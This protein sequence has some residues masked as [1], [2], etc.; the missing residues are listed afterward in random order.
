MRS[1]FLYTLVIIGLFGHGQ[2]VFSK[3]RECILVSAFKTSLHQMDSCI[4]KN[5]QK[6]SALYYKGLIYLKINNLKEAQTN[7]SLLI[8][9]YP[10][11]VEAHFLSGLIFLSEKNYA[12]SIDEFN[13]VLT[14]FPNHVNALYNRSQAFGALANYKKAIEDLNACLSAK[15]MYSQ[16]YCYRAS[17]HE[18]IGDHTKAIK[19]YE[20]TI[21]LDPKNFDAYI[22]LAYIYH[23]QK[24][25]ARSCAVINDAIKS[26]SQMAEEIK[27]TFCK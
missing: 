6:D 3:V 13:I 8:K 19:D 5:Y 27:Q 18:N 14:K 17:C 15:P 20:T 16:A 26:G 21:N 1:I 12:K 4:A 2:T 9:T 10:K 7:C 24:D 25:D 23:K 22:D 11:F